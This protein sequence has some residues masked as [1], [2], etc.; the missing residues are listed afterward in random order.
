MAG[1]KWWF[2]GSAA[3]LIP[4]VTLIMEWPSRQPPHQQAAPPLPGPAAPA[5]PAA[6]ARVLPSGTTNSTPPKTPSETA[7]YELCGIG[8]AS[9]QITADGLNEYVFALTQKTG[10]SW[11]AAL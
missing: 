1:K 11:R 5:R 9:A 7:K 2:A 4:T 6:V 10:D 3:L 8:K